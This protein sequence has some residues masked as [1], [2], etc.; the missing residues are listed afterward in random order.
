MTR[1][2]KVL[3]RDTKLRE[4][5]RDGLSISTFV[6][7]QTLFHYLLQACSVLS[8][9]EISTEGSKWELRKEPLILDQNHR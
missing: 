1:G 3:G 2:G 6:N 9:T 5:A 4:V 8:Q 7:K